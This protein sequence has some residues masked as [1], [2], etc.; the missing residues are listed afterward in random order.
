M[1]DYVKLKRRGEA[2]RWNINFA[3]AKVAFRGRFPVAVAFVW[4]LSL[5]MLALK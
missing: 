1:L 5:W 2:K 3:V 4:D